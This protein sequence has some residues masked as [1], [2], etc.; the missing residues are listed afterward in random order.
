[1]WPTYL[2]C[3]S[4]CRDT[5]GAHTLASHTVLPLS[6]DVQL[7]SFG[8]T[9]G[10]SPSSEEP[11][12]DDCRTPISPLHLHSYFLSLLRSHLCWSLFSCLGSSLKCNYLFSA[13]SLFLLKALLLILSIKPMP[14]WCRSLLSYDSCAHSIWPCPAQD[15][16]VSIRVQGEPGSCPDSG[17]CL[18][19]EHK[20]CL[21]LPLFWDILLFMHDW[22]WTTCLLAQT[23]WDERSTSKRD[24]FRWS[25]SFSVSLMSRRGI[26]LLFRAMCELK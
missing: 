12:W 4:G 26:T 11:H 14:K 7:S 1:M 15:A 25:H 5:T 22:I 19:V 20:A 16:G 23:R 10:P 2:L 24:G 21:A 17:S 18:G 13:H 9:A 3:S 6:P 8:T